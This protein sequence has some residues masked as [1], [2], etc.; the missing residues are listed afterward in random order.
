[1]SFERQMC[2]CDFFLNQIYVNG[3]KQK[4]Y[5]LK[6]FPQNCI[7]KSK[8]IRQSNLSLGYT[9]TQGIPV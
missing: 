4:V 2:F 5:N 1:M 8:V 6:L 9:I 7:K 3:A